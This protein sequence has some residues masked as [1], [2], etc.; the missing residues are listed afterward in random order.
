MKKTSR[1]KTK[2]AR[3]NELAREYRFDYRR[4]KP[5]RFAK[6]TQPEAIAVLLDPDVAQI[7][8]TSEAVNKVL[9]A[10]LPA[11]PVRGRLSPGK[12]VSRRAI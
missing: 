3:A 5:N 2:E 9:R 12:P 10:L 7:F 4:S 11:M 6:R 1:A 8:S